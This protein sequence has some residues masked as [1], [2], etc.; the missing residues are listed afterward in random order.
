MPLLS[1][2]AESFPFLSGFTQEIL[3]QYCMKTQSSEGIVEPVWDNK[4]SRS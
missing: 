4:E 2:D 3:G 1:L